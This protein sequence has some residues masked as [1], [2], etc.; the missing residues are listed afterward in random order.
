MLKKNI[1]AFILAGTMAFAIGCGRNE[2]KGPPIDADSTAAGKIRPDQQLRNAR[3]FLY[4]KAVR[5]TDIQAEYIEKYEKQ[6][7]TLAW[8][9]KVDF[10]DSTGKEI[11]HLVSD[12]GLV[13]ERLNLMIVNGHVVVIGENESRL[14]TEQL[15]WNGR[16]AKIET[17]AF[18][19]IIQNGDT[20]AQ[21]YGMESDERLT[22]I[23]IKKKVSGSLKNTQ[24]LDQ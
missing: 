2:V 8:K 12:S 11:S 13:R 3:I 10:F 17:D 14:E 15:I 21:G 19:R 18:V 4:T 5:T 24:G 22:K 1:F 20:T 7:S 6:D 9:L 16:E 23:K